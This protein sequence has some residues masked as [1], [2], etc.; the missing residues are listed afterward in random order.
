MLDATVK[1]IQSKHEQL[2]HIPAKFY[3]PTQTSQCE[4]GQFF[5]S[6]YDEDACDCQIPEIEED[7]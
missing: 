4:P 5:S 6:H 3:E 7:C 2:T 1:R